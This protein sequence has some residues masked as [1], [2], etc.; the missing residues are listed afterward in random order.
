MVEKG[1]ELFDLSY[2]DKPIQYDKCSYGTLL[3]E[4]FEHDWGEQLIQL[5]Y[6]KGYLKEISLGRLFHLACASTNIKLIKYFVEK[7]PD[8]NHYDANG[9]S[10][11]VI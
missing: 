4:L 6:E 3:E 5:L 2:L 1:A 7:G 9:N 11:L 8:V 10:A